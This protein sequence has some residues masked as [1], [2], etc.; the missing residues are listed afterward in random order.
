[1]ACV[2]HDEVTTTDELIPSGDTSSYRSNPLKLAEFTLSRKDPNYVQRAKDIQEMEYERRAFAVGKKLTVSSDLKSLMTQAY[3]LDAD[4]DIKDVLRSTSIGSVIFANKPGDGSAREQAASC[5]RVLGAL[6]NIA[7]D[8]ATKRYRSNVIN[9][10]MLPF[11]F[12]CDDFKVDDLVLVKD[13]RSAVESGADKVQA[14]LVR[15]GLLKSIELK[16]ENLSDKEREVILK[17]C[18]MNYYASEKE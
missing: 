11:T 4:A 5:Q 3:E 16:L 1:M 18:L 12:D 15:E 6:G 9:W 10:G 13:V 14:V 2:I 17:G 7:K 8:Y